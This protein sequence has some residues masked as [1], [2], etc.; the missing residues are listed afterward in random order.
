MP[1]LT[2]KF[3]NQKSMALELFCHRGKCEIATNGKELIFLKILWNKYK[4]TYEIGEFKCVFTI[5]I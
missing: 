2:P 5:E 3:K 4:G 1:E